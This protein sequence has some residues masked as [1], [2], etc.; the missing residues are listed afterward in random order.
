M[1]LASKQ[2]RERF[3]KVAD[4]IHLQPKYSSCLT[5]LEELKQ[6]WRDMTTLPDYP[7]IDFPLELP[8]WFPEVRFASRWQK[9]FLSKTLLD[10][11]NGII[12]E[13]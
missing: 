5:E 6:K 3:F 7:D 2:D 12:F 10:V 9:G 11:Q 1:I 8:T 13:I 4:S